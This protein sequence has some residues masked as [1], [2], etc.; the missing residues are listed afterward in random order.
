MAFSNPFNF[1]SSFFL[2]STFLA[3][4][5]NKQRK[6]YYNE[7][8]TF[9]QNFIV[10]KKTVKNNFEISMK[11]EN[12]QIVNN[13]QWVNSILSNEDVSNLKYLEKLK[14]IGRTVLKNTDLP[15]RND[16]AWRFT[17]LN[18]LLKM[19]FSEIKK[20]NGIKFP[21][22]YFIDNFSARIVFVDGF[23]SPSNSYI[24]KKEKGFFLGNFSELEE[25]NQKSILENIGKGESGINGGFF[26]ILNMACLNE[27]VVLSLSPGFQLDSPI[28]IIFAGSEEKNQFCLNQR[29]VI[30]AEKYSIAEIIQHHISL[31]NSEY[32][33]NSAT[34]IIIKEGAKVNFILANEI[35]KKAALVNSI[36][37]ELEKDS[38]FGFL[39][40]SFGGFLSRLNLGIDLNGLKSKC[41]VQGITV[42]DTVQISD[43]HSRISHNYPNCNSSQIHKNLVS[44][45]AHAI[46]AGK[47]Q[48][49]N[50]ASDTQ[51]DQLC[52]TLL[53]SSSSKVDSMP[54]LEINNENVKCTHGSTVS[55][56]DDDQLFY[57]QSRGISSEKARFFLTIGFVKEIIQKFPKELLKRFSQSV[58]SLV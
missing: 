2:K 47:V 16:E 3:K 52:K 14:R 1:S 13:S 41:D 49:H 34:N 43:I 57:F 48:V 29:L 7:K 50:G 10:L 28:Q 38:S 35:S 46:F 54:I 20:K 19:K 22:G 55:D 40:A 58:D 32:F 21:D 51:S 39:S 23:F 9:F 30:L 45:K 17:P 56:L 25:E 44:G 33:D 37:A 36:H 11:Q 18:K 31:G 12:R 6:V 26:P 4:N 5:L 24:P 27:I 53:L 8:A 42:V 15:S